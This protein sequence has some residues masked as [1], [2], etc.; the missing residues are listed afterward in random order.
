[1]KAI[2]KYNRLISAVVPYSAE[3]GVVHNDINLECGSVIF[4]DTGGVALDYNANSIGAN[5]GCR[6]S[7]ITI[8]LRNRAEKTR[9]RPENLSL[10]ISDNNKL[11]RRYGGKIKFSK[12]IKAITLDH[13]D[14]TCQYLKIHCDLNDARFTFSEDCKNIL[15][16]YGP[17][18]FDGAIT[19]SRFQS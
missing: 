6:K 3:T 9:V 19:C 17:P 15:E 8:R 2:Q 1:L 12:E 4:G 11:Y 7:V 16:I 14:F 13:L 10:W 5:L 18:N